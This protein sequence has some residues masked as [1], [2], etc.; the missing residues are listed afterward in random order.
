LRAA[1]V[2]GSEDETFLSLTDAQE[3]AVVQLRFFASDGIPTNVCSGVLIGD[4][5]VLTVAHCIDR[6]ERTI[7]E[8]RFGARAE[9]PDH[10]VRVTEVL[11]HPDFEIAV[12]R[13]RAEDLPD[14]YATPI[15]LPEGEIARN[16][17][18]SVATLAGHGQSEFES[19]TTRR[20]VSETVTAVGEEFLVTSGGELSGACRGDSG[21]PLFGRALDGFVRVYGV[22]EDGTL[23]CRGDDRYTR[24]DA[25]PQWEGFAGSTTTR[26]TTACGEITEEGRCYGEAAVWCE[27]GQ[28]RRMACPAGERCGFSS[29][30]SGYRCVDAASD[31]CAGVPDSG[32]CDGSRALVCDDGVLLRVDCVECAD[33]CVIVPTN[34]QVACASLEAP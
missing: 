3:N 33:R 26:E 6:Q 22:L 7:G 8:I 28:L 23:I 11:V 15:P 27:G 2:G 14:G 12:A 25:D 21:G 32:Q 1:I 16:L 29:G 10:L 20:F 13:F 24:V 30:A 4:D 34:G 5:R 31:P 17:V 18:G 9:S 19:V